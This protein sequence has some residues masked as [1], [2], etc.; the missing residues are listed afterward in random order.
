MMNGL[1]YACCICMQ[2]NPLLSPLDALDGYN[3]NHLEKLTFCAPNEVYRV[4]ITEK[5]F[6]DV[7]TEF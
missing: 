3:V 6:D 1:T 7:S 2:I 4:F 5:T